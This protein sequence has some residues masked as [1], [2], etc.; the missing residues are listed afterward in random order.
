MS[1]HNISKNVFLKP[2]PVPFSCNKNVMFYSIY[3]KRKPLHLLSLLI[4]YFTRHL[5]VELKILLDIRYLS[6]R[7][8]GYL[9]DRPYICRAKSVPVSGA[10]LENM[11]KKYLYEDSTG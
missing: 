11:N 9:A 7:F 4:S 3:D 10:S 2:L 5:D 1:I 6:F 8:A